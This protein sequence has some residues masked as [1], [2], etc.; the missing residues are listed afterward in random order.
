[1][2]VGGTGYGIRGQRNKTD[3]IYS[4]LNAIL[5]E[6]SYYNETKYSDD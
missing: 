6:D 4:S 2:V 3:E 5:S 1:M